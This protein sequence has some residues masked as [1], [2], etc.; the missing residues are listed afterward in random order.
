M[1]AIP[2]SIIGS[3]IMQ[4]PVKVNGNEVK[5][6]MDTGIGPT[7]LS[8]D[9][10]KELGLDKVGTMAGRRMSGKELEMTLVR[11]PMIEF[12]NEVRENLEV[13]I[14]DTSRFPNDLKDIKGILSIGFFKDSV[15]TIDYS[16]S[17]LYVTDSLNMNMPFGEGI[18]FPLEAEY[19]GPS[20]TLYTR[21]KLPSGRVVK[22]EVDTGSDVLIVNSKLMGELGISP[23][24]ED[25]ESV[26]G[27]DETGYEYERFIATMKGEI[28]IE[29]N[30]WITQSNPRVIFQDIIHDGL[31]GHD[32]LKKYIVSFDI[33]GK[34]MIFY[35][36]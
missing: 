23:N 31:I 13:G 11:V 3:H 9:F 10:V 25:V 32:F 30:N 7:V 29:G 28:A 26:R 1:E 12:G 8:K 15:L 2:F 14:F 34:K 5:F 20:V 24:D 18:R 27:T 22:F 35:K 19:D 33:G 36:R 21:V 6:L 16:N 17:L 4:I